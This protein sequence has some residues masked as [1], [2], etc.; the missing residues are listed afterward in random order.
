MTVPPSAGGAPVIDDDVPPTVPGVPAGAL[1]AAPVVPD[2]PCAKAA[3]LMP[4]AAANNVVLIEVRVF[5][6]LLVIMRVSAE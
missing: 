2:I 5:I 4:S 6:K 1:P 3:V